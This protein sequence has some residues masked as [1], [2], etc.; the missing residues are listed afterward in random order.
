MIQPNTFNLLTLTSDISTLHH[1]ESVI[2]ECADRRH[3]LQENHPGP[4]EE[5]FIAWRT[6]M[7]EILGG[8]DVG[9]RLLVATPVPPLTNLPFDVGHVS[10]IY[11]RISEITGLTWEW[12]TI[13]RTQSP[14]ARAEF[15]P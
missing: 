11:S 1:I 14:S 6:E 10:V 3:G 12:Q 8:F 2:S 4:A 5:C 15:V 9:C 13:R 7:M